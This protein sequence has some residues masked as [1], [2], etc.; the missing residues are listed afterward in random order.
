MRYA[1]KALTVAANPSRVMWTVTLTQANG[2]QIA[3]KSWGAFPD[4]TPHEPE[5]ET[6]PEAE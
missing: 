2:V 3:R 4:M 5:P 1:V 6:E